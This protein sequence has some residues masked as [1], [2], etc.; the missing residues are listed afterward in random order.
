V[1]SALEKKLDDWFINFSYDIQEIL[2]QQQK[3]IIDFLTA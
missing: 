2:Q 1:Q 3:P